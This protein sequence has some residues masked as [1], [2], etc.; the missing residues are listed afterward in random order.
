MVKIKCR[1]CHKEYRK[2][3]Y[4][5]KIICPYCNCVTIMNNFKEVRILKF[6][7]FL[8]VFFSAHWTI[9]KINLYMPRWCAMILAC[10]LLVSISQICY[11]ILVSFI[12]RRKFK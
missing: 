11:S 5:Y 2:I 7:L 6:C 3:F 10:I 12:Y 1:K 4:G 9:D 8:F